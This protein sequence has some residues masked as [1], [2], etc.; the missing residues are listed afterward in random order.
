MPTDNTNNLELCYNKRTLE[1]R[2]LRLGVGMTTIFLIAMSFQWT[3]AY[4]APIFLPLILQAGRPL[5]AKEAIKML[6]AVLIIM[7]GTYFLSAIS[8]QLPFLFALLLIPLLFV[9]FRSLY[10]GGSALV[11]L[12]TLIGLSVPPMTAKISLDLTWDISA[13]FVW[14]IGLCVMVSYLLFA[15]FPPLAG[16]PKPQPRPVFPPAEAERRAA[17]LAIIVGG[18]LLLY[19]SLDWHNAHTPAYIAVFASSLAFSRTTSLAKG[20]L[21]ANV[22]GGLVAV[23]MYE[24]TVAVPNFIFL[25]TLT[26]PVMLVFARAVLSDAPWAPLASF[27]M[28]VV[29]LILGPSISPSIGP[30]ETDS[31]FENMTY[32]LFELSI[33]ALYAIITVFVFE[34]F[35]PAKTQPS[36]I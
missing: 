22:V 21:A 12:M 17:S 20:I 33:A 28:S 31:G 29:L 30:F 23:V 18:F 2:A 11:V 10:R 4:L 6:F 24:L 13:S 8:R 7:L 1:H 3:L 15:I 19:L 27:S 9:T 14:N 36:K 34:A 25:A 32:R 16:E 35:I 5:S 26:L